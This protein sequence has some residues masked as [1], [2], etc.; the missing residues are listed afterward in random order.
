MAQV[1][2]GLRLC[3]NIVNH[4]HDLNMLVYLQMDLERAGLNEI[5]EALKQHHNPEIMTLVYLLICS[6]HA[7]D[8]TSNPLCG[9]CSLVM[10]PPI[11]LTYYLCVRACA[12]VRVCM[13]MCFLVCCWSTGQRLPIKAHQRRNDCAITRGKL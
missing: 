7:P 6:H 4:A 9:G 13:H 11:S 3:L 5:A 10:P 2:A 8:V 1:L 12:C